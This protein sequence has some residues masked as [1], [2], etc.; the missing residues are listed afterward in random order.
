V[1]LNRNLPNA[2]SLRNF[3]HL[4]SHAFT[5]TKTAIQA[6]ILESVD[7]GCGLTYLMYTPIKMS[8]LLF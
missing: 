4:G 6:A 1:F 3:G 7:N 2:S 8:D 5:S